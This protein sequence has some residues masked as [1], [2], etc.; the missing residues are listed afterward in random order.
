MPSREWTFE[1]TNYGKYDI[2]LFDTR[3]EMKDEIIKLQGNCIDAPMGY[4]T[5]DQDI[6]GIMF[7]IADFLEYGDPIA[8]HEAGHLA[9]M[10]LRKT[11]YEWESEEPFLELQEKIV[12]SVTDCIYATLAECEVPNALT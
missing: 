2:T 4:I 9:F 8:W 3:D 7:N 12:K 10:F 1:A 5:K 6:P 11:E